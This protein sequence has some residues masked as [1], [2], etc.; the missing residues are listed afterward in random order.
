MS[1]FS[2]RDGSRRSARLRK[3][4]YFFEKTKDQSVSANKQE[5]L[6]AYS[7]DIKSI[8]SAFKLEN[9]YR[10]AQNIFYSAL[11]VDFTYIRFCTKSP[12]L[13]GF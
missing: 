11:Q 7:S 2:C 5:I 13:R 4:R 9:L 10:K 3:S 8:K 1:L 12:V 6:C